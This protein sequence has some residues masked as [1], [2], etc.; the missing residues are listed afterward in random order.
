[1]RKA[2]ELTPL[3]IEITKHE[4][5]NVLTF[6]SSNFRVLSLSYSSKDHGEL[7]YSICLGSASQSKSFTY[8]HTVGFEET[9]LVGN[10]YFS[11]YVKWQGRAREA[12]LH[13]NVM[14]ISNA[15]GDLE[16]ISNMLSDGRLALVTCSTDC[17][18]LRELLAFDEVIIHLTLDYIIENRIGMSFSYRKVTEEG[19]IIVAT[20]KQ[21][22]ACMERS[23][24]GNAINNYR[25]NI[26][27]E[28]NAALLPFLQQI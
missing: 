10:V 22:I 27:Q 12:F 26:P 15:K 4:E 19:E 20:G 11:N 9:N 8:S 18:Y 2:G 25:G 7:I 17:K 6:T 3:E 14:K 16:L 5:S 24:N 28:F 23:E 1:M 21:E 13:Q